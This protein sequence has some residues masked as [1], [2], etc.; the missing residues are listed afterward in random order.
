MFAERRGRAAFA[1]MP[2]KCWVA[3]YDPRNSFGRASDWDPTD[4]LATAGNPDMLSKFLNTAVPSH[5]DKCYECVWLPMCAGGCPY[6][7]LRGHRSCVPFKDEPERYV[8]ALNARMKRE[9]AREKEG[10]ES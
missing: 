5:D 4:P 6:Q 8:L 9:Q 2:H 10:R 1:P 7:R 3:M